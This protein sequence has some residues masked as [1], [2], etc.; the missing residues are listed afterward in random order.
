MK[1]KYNKKKNLA[2]VMIAGTGS[3]V[4][5]SVIATAFCRIFKQDGYTPAPFK[6]QNMALNSYV[7]PEGFE[8]GRAQAVQAEAAGLECHTDMN[9]LLLKPAGDNRSQVVLNGVAIGT[10]S[11]SALFREERRNLYIEDVHDAYDRLAR[12]HHPMVIEGAGSIAEMNL[13]KID[14]INMD[15]A[16]HSNADVILVADIERGGVFGS[17]Y[18]SIMLQEPQDRKRIKGIIINKFRGDTSLFEE[19]IVML[20]I[21]TQIKVLGVVPHYDDI[22]IDEEDS[23]ALQSK[24]FDAKKDR[25]NICVVL[26]KH[27]SNF[28]DFNVLERDKRVHLFYTDNPAELAKAD[29]IIIPGTKN[30]IK[31]LIEIR[32][33]GIANAI[34][35]AHDTGKTVMGICGGYQMMG[36]EIFDPNNVEGDVKWLPG[37][38]LLP[39]MTTLKKKKLTRQVLFTVASDTLDAKFATSKTLCKG[40]E[41]HVGETHKI[42]K[43]PGRELTFIVN[44]EDKSIE[45]GSR[46][47]FRAHECGCFLDEKCFGTY[48]HGALDNGPMIDFLLA[49]HLDKNSSRTIFDYPAFKEEQYDKLAAYVRKHIDMDKVYEILERPYN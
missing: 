12:K 1:K 22:F 33:N 26:L 29:I 15:M 38:S 25:I 11:A 4:G 5:K 30:T 8:L 45:K 9:P 10:Q 35:R 47:P 2:P 23:L 18:G 28:T 31:D 46:K 7:T 40:Y 21:L 24:N 41:V 39:V 17:V 3:D 36:R 43:T 20:E 34:K 6:A 49:P 48:I 16:S 13:K 44:K 37:L 42:K 27:I 19:G 32:R 14:F